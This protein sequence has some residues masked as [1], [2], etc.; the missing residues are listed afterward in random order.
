MSSKCVVKDGV[1]WH[2]RG[3][4]GPDDVPVPGM[5]ATFR[6]MAS[7]CEIL[8]YGLESQEEAQ[9][10]GK[11]AVD[12]VRR[13]EAKYSRFNH[14]SVLSQ[15]NRDAGERQPLDPETFG[16]LSFAREC[17][18]HSDGLFDISSEP[19][20]RLWRFDGSND[21]PGAEDVQKALAHVGFERLK[22]T[23]TSILQP[24]DMTLD[25]GGIAKE[26]AADRALKLMQ[27]QLGSIAIEP[28][29]L[30]NL[31]GDLAASPHESHWRVGIEDPDNHQAAK[32]SIQ[33][34]G[35][36]LATSGDSHRF[37]ERHGKRYGHILSPLS[38]YPIEGA[39][40]SV[41][42]MAA[43]CTVAGMLATLAMLKGE[44]AEDFLEE[45]D[46]PYWVLR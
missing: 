24:R 39:P 15:L 16:L 35:G 34:P 27:E 21:V 44:D 2:H 5:A 30:V 23:S 36:G 1:K 8:F 22:F 45:Q 37:I 19:L 25:L 33:F 41:T 32:L 46:L 6:A 18:R 31:G 12:E 3:F 11:V 9:R 14:D 38:G 7:P 17:Y 28:A 29:I 40:R 42:V 10:L 43:N 4:M 26:Y 13:I 20:S